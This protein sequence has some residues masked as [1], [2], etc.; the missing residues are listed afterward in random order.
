MTPASRATDDTIAERVNAVEDGLTSTHWPHT[1]ATLGSSDRTPEWIRR[2]MR[3]TP[4]QMSLVTGR[5][6]SVYEHVDARTFGQGPDD[7]F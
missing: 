1:L 2:D 5:S 6:S 3:L 7:Y 4:Q